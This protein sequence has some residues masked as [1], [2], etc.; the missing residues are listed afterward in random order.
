MEYRRFGKTEKKISVITLGGMRY[1][2]G[3]DKPRELLPDDTLEQCTH[4]VDEAF[5]RGIN[6]FESAYGYCKSE[7][8][9][10][11]VLNEH[12]N[13][14][15][16]KYFF[17]TKGQ[18]ATWDDTRKLVE[19]QLETLKMD[20]FDFY[21]WHGMNNVA[22]YEKACAK[23]GPVE[24]L[25]RLKEEGLIRHVGFSSHAPVDCI[26]RIIETDLFE[27]VN[28]HHYYFDQNKLPAVKL[29][30]QKDMGILI[31]SPNDKGGQLFF[32]PEK[33]K[34]MT[35]PLTPIQWNA[36]YCLSHPAVTTLSFGMTETSHFEEMEGIFPAPAPLSEPDK[37]ILAELDKQKM[38][39]PYS[40]YNGFDLRDDPSG[41]NIPE[42]LRFRAMW[43]CYDMD[44]FC[45]YRYNMF[46][47]D[48]TWFPGAFATEDRLKLIDTSKIPSE[49][50]LLEMLAE[51][52]DR[53]YL[54]KA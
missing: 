44:T 42:I 24:A 15:R 48:G 6:I 47:Q 49:I 27:F 13:I 34:K 26:I 31:I 30:Q 36:R 45:S 43:K 7:H 8:T 51:F 39:D 40:G 21:A 17:M 23:A 19:E 14:P 29:A 32:A 5:K 25:H 16:E 35:L 3:W 2:H 37:R 52:H 54:P 28:L 33:L 18:P 22:E 50:P 9:Y 12:L 10:S 46:E 20:Y 1:V 4:C 41:L 38:L 11:K 53:F